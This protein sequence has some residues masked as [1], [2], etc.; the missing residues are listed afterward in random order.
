M[1]VIRNFLKKIDIVKYLQRDV[2]VG[3][4]PTLDS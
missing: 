2:V 4:L 1:K 3:L